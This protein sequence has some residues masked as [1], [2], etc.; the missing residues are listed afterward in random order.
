MRSVRKQLTCH[1]CGYTLNEVYNYCPNCGQENNNNNVS[2]GTLIREFLDNYFG[3]DSK[4]A[5]SVAPF[6]F[7][8]GTL[9]N[10]FQ[11]GRI[12]HFIHPIR[13]YLVMSL[14]YFF[15]ISHLLSKYTLRTIEESS[16]YDDGLV[17]LKQLNRN[18]DLKLLA[19]STKFELLADSLKNKFSN[20]RSY[21]ALFDSLSTLYDED[22]LE[23]LQV[24]ISN[25]EIP[26]PE[27][28]TRLEKLNRLARDRR[29]VTNEAF[30]D[31]INMDASNTFLSEKNYKHTVEQVR[32]ILE[33]DKGFK[34]F[35]L[36]NLP[37]MMFILIPLFAGVLKLIYVRRKHLYIK[38]IVH[39][40][41]V[42]S[43]AF[44]F[45]G[46][47]LYIMNKLIGSETW[48]EI[49]GFISFVLVSAYVY[50][51][52]LKVYKQGWFKT[53]VKFNMVGFVYL[54]LI[55]TFFTLEL[56]ISFWYY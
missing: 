16:N 19:D 6:L 23:D 43:F 27:E 2:F 54:L 51:S 40:L 31:S 13:L 22:F 7:K 38:H 32:K 17:T 21:T 8:P 9:T 15:I 47:S 50:I 30:A 12:K 48:S 11:E 36:G 24:D 25:V 53:L 10:R 18:S 29:R 45:Y 5:H 52:F 44:L 28:E 4:L 49:V 3:I 35:V 46:I 56:V 20:T 14:L 37:L 41:H 33:D 26:V 34:N 55:T 39:S 1:N 42:H